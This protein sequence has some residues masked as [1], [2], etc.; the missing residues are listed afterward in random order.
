MTGKEADDLLRSRFLGAVDQN[1]FEL[2]MFEQDRDLDAPAGAASATVMN[3]LHEREADDRTGGDGVIDALRA[4]VKDAFDAR[5]GRPKGKLGELQK[6]AEKAEARRDELAHRIATLTGGSDG[7]DLVGQVA[8]LRDE[9]ADVALRIDRADAAAKAVAARKLLDA[10]KE[11]VRQRGLLVEQSD[12]YTM[13]AKELNDAVAATRARLEVLEKALISLEQA[14]KAA[15]KERE[16]LL[17]AAAQAEADLIAGH[18]RTIEL[19][20]ADLKQEKV[21]E[22]LVKRA[23][24]LDREVAVAK[25]GLESGAWELRV[26]AGRPLRLEIDGE[27]NELKKGAELTRAVSASLMLDDAEGTVLDLHADA[28]RRDAVEKLARSSAALTELLS[29]V[30]APDLDALDERLVARQKAEK[31]IEELQRTL[32]TLRKEPVTDPLPPPDASALGKGTARKGSTTAPDLDA[33]ASVQEEASA[34][35][36]AAGV[37]GDRD[38]ADARA[39]REQALQLLAQQELELARS[40]ARRTETEQ[41]LA[42]ARLERSDEALDDEVTRAAAAVDA[43]GDVDEAEDVST[44]KALK[45]RRSLELEEIQR[46]AHVAE[47]RRLSAGAYTATLGNLE[48]D[49][50]A[51]RT[52]FDRDLRDAQ[53]ARTLLVRLEEAREAQGDRYREPLQARIGE[54]LSGLYG[55]DCRVELDDDLR[56]VLRSEPDGSMVPWGQLSGGAKEQ[57]A[58]V[59]GLAIAELAGEGGVPFWIDDAIVFTDDD[60]IEGL[61]A[62]LTATSAQVIVLTCRADL[63]NGLPAAT[64]AFSER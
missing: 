25:G 33:L 27:P 45:E 50:A 24:K 46:R 57:A 36:T 17:A 41:Q 39:A 31:R 28:S 11:L 6:T 56:I 30:G 18:E 49:A 64:F 16:A 40:T 22:P 34:R 15:G 42:V 19:L 32:E 60:R 4:R 48:E 21:D 44:L 23:Q 2:L 13:E 51:L 26:N 3:A 52:E 38:L 1:L 7:I 59:T 20:T 63:A 35:L 43:I 55:Y 37:D 54:L 9:L 62:L 10:A 29:D 8:A 58:V 61:K 47:G 14:A 53:A 12:R 5:N